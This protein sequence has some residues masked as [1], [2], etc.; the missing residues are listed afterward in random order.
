MKKIIVVV[1][2]VDL[3]ASC[4]STYKSL[5]QDSQPSSTSQQED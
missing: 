4:V 3:L 5:P 1:I 2:S